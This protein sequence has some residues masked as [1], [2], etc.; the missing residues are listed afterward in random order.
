MTKTNPR[1][2][3]QRARARERTKD[4]KG[5]RQARGLRKAMSCLLFNCV[6][7]DWSQ[8]ERARDQEA[9]KPPFVRNE[10]IADNTACEVLCEVD[11]E[12]QRCAK[13]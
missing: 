6:V 3:S 11:D 5:R 13:I 10:L 8:V 1:S 9:S 4:K 7:C 12:E 2:P